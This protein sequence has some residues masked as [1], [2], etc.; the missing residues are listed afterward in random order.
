MAK[1]IGKRIVPKH[2]GYWDKTKAYEM[3]CIVYNR[4]DG[5]SYISRRAVPADTDITQTEYWALCSGFSEQMDLLEKHFTATEQRIVADND[6][7]E[8]A[9]RADNDETERLIKAD[10][11]ATKQY[12]DQ[13]LQETTSS[14]TRAINDAVA[15]LSAGRQQ[16]AET[17]E[18]LSARMNSIVAGGTEDAEVLDARVDHLGKTYENLGQHLRVYEKDAEEKYASIFDQNRNMIDLSSFTAGYYINQGNGETNSNPAHSVS[19]Y[20]PVKP[21]TSYVYSNALGFYGSIR[22]CFYDAEKRYISGVMEETA[23]T[24]PA[25]ARYIRLS[26]MTNYLEHDGQLEEGTE[27]TEWVPYGK[28]VKDELVNSYTKDEADALLLA[29]RNRIIQPAN[30]SFFWASRNLFDRNA[31][32][33]GYYIN[34]GNGQ[35]GSNAAHVCTDYLEIEPN[36]DYTFSGELGTALRIAFYNV[37]KLFLEGYYNAE[38]TTPYT[39]H[40]PERAAYIRFSVYGT[41]FERSEL[42]FEKGS[43]ATPYTLFGSAHLLNEY[44]PVKDTFLLNLPAK[45][46]ALVGEELNIYFDNLVDGHDTDYVFNVDCNVGRQLERCY[47][48]EPI[49]TIIINTMRM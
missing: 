14:L 18:A 19:D 7:T 34:Q 5:N 24:T 37:D 13:N 22:F 38:G 11:T 36:A 8:A 42:Q 48:L 2:C 20:L 43:E 31:V 45:L 15:D 3:E 4:A 33:R 21:N 10:N 16:L 35:T 23:F 28:L 40:A 9:I 46:Y 49:I 26:D 41:V 29:V 39:V 32:I 25:S 30:T 12:V 27:P 1:Y 17:D 6:A 47:R 44:A